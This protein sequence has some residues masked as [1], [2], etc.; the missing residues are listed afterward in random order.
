VISSSRNKLEAKINGG[1]ERDTL[2]NLRRGCFSKERIRKVK[3]RSVAGG[4]TT[5]R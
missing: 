1:G 3:K 2:F 5:D 4:P